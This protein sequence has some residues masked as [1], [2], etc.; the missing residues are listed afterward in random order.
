MSRTLDEPPQQHQVD[1]AAVLRVC[2]RTRLTPS[3]EEAEVL[4]VGREIGGRLCHSSSSIVRLLR[5]TQREPASNV[6][7][8]CPRRGVEEEQLLCDVVAES[9][10]EG[11]EA[12]WFCMQ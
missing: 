9:S 2:H 1:A 10:A 7:S 5:R 8:A 6:K 3:V 12:D 11:D 4:P